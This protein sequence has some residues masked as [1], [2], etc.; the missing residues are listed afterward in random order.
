[1]Y[2]RARC[3]HGLAL[4]QTVS[5]DSIVALGNLCYHTLKCL[6]RTT[7][8]ELGC[9]GSNHILHLL[10]PAYTGCKLSDEVV[11]DFCSIGVSLCV[12]ILI[13]G[14]DRSLEFC[15]FDGSLELVLGRLHEG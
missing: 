8:D 5:A 4:C 7:L 12:Y 1:M 9:T 10:C 14:A 6:A 2:V 3:S 11:L 13:Y 15:L